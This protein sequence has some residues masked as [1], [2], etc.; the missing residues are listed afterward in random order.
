MTDDVQ[1]SK[2]IVLTVVL[3]LTGLALIA[4]GIYTRDS[5]GNFASWILVSCGMVVAI[6]TPV[7]WRRK[8]G[9]QPK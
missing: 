6:L 1:R 3:V 5:I 2:L 4:A 8:R 9:R 7:L